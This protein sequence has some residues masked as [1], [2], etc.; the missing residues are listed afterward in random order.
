MKFFRTTTDI[1]RNLR[2]EQTPEEKILWEI[3]RNRRL[4]GFKFLRQHPIVYDRSSIPNKFIIAD[5]FC[6]EK[7][8]IIEV[9]GGIHEF[10]KQKD[11]A[12][13][14]LMLNKGFKTL[15]VKN[16]EFDEIDT[17]VE[18]IKKELNKI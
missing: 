4:S 7:K 14:V 18:K 11:Q 5:F 1:A 12:R 6:S 9:D 2:K 8:L 15:R 13:D 16:N 10:Q 3:L 17:I